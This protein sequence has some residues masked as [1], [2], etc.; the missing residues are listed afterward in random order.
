MVISNSL[1][2][3]ITIGKIFFA[4]LTLIFISACTKDYRLSIVGVDFKGNVFYDFY[5][6]ETEFL[7]SELIFGADFTVDPDHV[8]GYSRVGNVSIV[9]PVVEDEL[10]LTSNQDFILSN[11][12]LKAGEN[13]IDYFEYKMLHEDFYLSYN[14]RNTED[15]LNKTGYYKFY[16]TAVLSGNTEVSD[17]CLVKINF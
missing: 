2:K 16:F 1:L 17:S 6:V 7:S 9:N 5:S 4:A 14:F 12:T 10:I 13:L 8:I 3:R 15:F 11:D